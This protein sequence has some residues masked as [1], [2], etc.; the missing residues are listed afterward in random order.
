MTTVRRSASIFPVSDVTAAMEHYRRLGFAT[1][2]KAVATRMPR[3]TPLRSTSQGH[4]ALIQHDD[5]RRVLWVEAADALAREW[6][7][8][9]VRVATP[10]D[11]DWGSTRALILIRTATSS[12][13]VRQSA[14]PHRAGTSDIDGAARQD[15][16]HTLSGLIVA[17]RT[18]DGGPDGQPVR[19]CLHRSSKPTPATTRL[20]LS[21]G[22]RIS[23]TQSGDKHSDREDQDGKQKGNTS[24]I[25]NVTL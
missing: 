22:N 18:V 11:T 13:S 1:N 17:T 25:L 9:G 23:A 10:I 15:L 16:R 8:A 20:A 2:R 4:A 19:Q 7:T 12:G 5:K 14:A 21:S 6:A 3:A 24:E